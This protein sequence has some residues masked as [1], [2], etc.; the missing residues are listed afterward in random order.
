MTCNKRLCGFVRAHSNLSVLLL[1]LD[2]LQCLTLAKGT[3]LFVL[4][5]RIVDENKLEAIPCYNVDATIIQT[6]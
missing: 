4:P 2:I 1:C 5:V 3:K 6:M